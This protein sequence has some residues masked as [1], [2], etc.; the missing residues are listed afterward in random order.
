MDL[1]TWK[2]LGSTA[3]VQS[4]AGRG[5]LKAQQHSTCQDGP[6]RGWRLRLSA[7]S[8]AGAVNQSS[9]VRVASPSGLHC[10]KYGGCV[11]RVTFRETGNGNC[12]S[13]KAQKLAQCHFCHFLCHRS[14]RAHPNSGATA[15]ESP[16]ICGHVWSAAKPH[17]VPATP[18][19]TNP[20][21]RF[22][23][24]VTTLSP[25]STDDQMLSQLTV[26]ASEL[27]SQHSVWVSQTCSLYYNLWSS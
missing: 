20:S 19:H 7:G 9:Y 15:E 14:Y 17:V 6:R 8:F 27:D 26:K 11:P 5:R 18:P 10:A 4:V 23:H 13:L 12:W 21:D 24:T 22:S 25:P 3:Q 1:D 2:W 16:R